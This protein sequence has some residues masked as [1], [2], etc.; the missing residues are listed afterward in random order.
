VEGKHRRVLFIAKYLDLFPT[1]FANS[2]AQGFRNGF[3]RGE[4]PREGFCP[5]AALFQFSRRIDA[6]KVMFA[7]ARDHF[8][9]AVNFDQINTGS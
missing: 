7:V 2:T 8:R 6:L 4:T 5:L 3:L 9:Y 1:H